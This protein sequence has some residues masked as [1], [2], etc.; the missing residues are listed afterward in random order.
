MK[1]EISNGIY[2]ESSGNTIALHT[3]A[4]EDREG[5]RI[6][7]SI[8]YLSPDALKKLALFASKVWQLAEDKGV[9]K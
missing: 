7:G 5:N 9:K 8:I 1:T 3:K 2:A 6:P 4:T